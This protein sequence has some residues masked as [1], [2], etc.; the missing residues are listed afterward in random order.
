MLMN[1]FRKYHSS[2][3][4]STVFCFIYLPHLKGQSLKVL[5]DIKPVCGKKRLGTAALWPQS[6]QPG[7]PSCKLDYIYT[8]FHCESGCCLVRQETRLECV[9]R[10][11]VLDTPALDQPTM[12]QVTLESP[13]S[14]RTGVSGAS[15]TRH[16]LNL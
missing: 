15:L 5:S 10:G 4:G 12:L 11:L 2:H 8:T 14:D 7:F 13:V 16:L 1:I 3:D 9:P 6:I